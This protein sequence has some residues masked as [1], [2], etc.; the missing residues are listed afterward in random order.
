MNGKQVYYYHI[1][2]CANIEEELEQR[3]AYP[4]VHFKNEACAEDCYVHQEPEADGR[5]VIPDTDN[6][7]PIPTTSTDEPDGARSGRDG[8]GRNGLG[9]IQRRKNPELCAGNQGLGELTRDGN[10]LLRLNIFLFF[11]FSI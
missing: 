1:I 2:T 11:R 8:T 6:T 3:Q 4:I 9:Q 10:F 7:T 5:G